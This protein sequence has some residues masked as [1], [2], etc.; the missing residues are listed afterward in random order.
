M[1]AVN[2]VSCMW[3]Q[4]LKREKLEEYLRNQD[5]TDF[6]KFNTCFYYIAHYKNSW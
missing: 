3:L 4:V 2:V 5:Q 1:E 6:G